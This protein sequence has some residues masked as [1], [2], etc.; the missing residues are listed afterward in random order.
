MLNVQQA[1]GINGETAEK[2]LEEIGILSSRQTLPSDTSPKM[3]EASGLRLGTAWA[4]SR[5]YR[6][7]EFTEIADIICATLASKGEEHILQTMSQRVNTLASRERCEDV[8]A[9]N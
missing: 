6:A 3:S 8:W 9:N 1:F 5:G 2:R 7:E 4:T